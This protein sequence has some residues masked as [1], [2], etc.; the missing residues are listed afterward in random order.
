MPPLSSSTASFASSSSHPAPVPSSWSSWSAWE[1]SSSSKAAPPLSSESSESSSTSSKA[2]PASSSESSSTSSKAAPASSS[3]S[4][5]SSSKPTPPPRSTSSSSSTTSSK[6]APL[7][8]SSSSSSSYPAPPSSS[9]SST[10]APPST[11]SISSSHPAPLTT[12]TSSSSSS[13]P[14]PTSSS[15]SSHPAWTSSSSS[16][17][18]LPTPSAAPG[19]CDSIGS[20]QFVDSLKENYT[21][22]CNTDR[23]GGDVGSGAS[24]SFSGCF[25]LC[26][27]TDKCVGFAYTGGSGPGTCYLKNSNEAP[28]ANENVDVAYMPSGAGNNPVPTPSSPASPG[29]CAILGSSTYGAYSVEC[30]IDHPAGDLKQVSSST[31]QGCFSICDATSECIG[32]AY[33]PGTCYL[34]NTMTGASGNGD[35]DSGFK[36]TAT[37]PSG[38]SCPHVS[39]VTVTALPTGSKM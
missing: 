2:A 27:M 1:T 20:G 5:S 37:L 14:V 7:P 8:S 11:S 29:S 9:S 28:S 21:I 25:A 34:K 38:C 10:L 16:S 26:D 33:T 4:S 39:T 18:S 6:P 15:S 31:Y 13:Y 24:A 19:S 32:F 17:Q 22:E 12:S 3:E 36:K 30:G 23:A 35:V